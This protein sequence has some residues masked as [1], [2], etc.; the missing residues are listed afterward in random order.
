MVSPAAGRCRSFLHLGCSYICTVFL[1]CLPPCK[2]LM[3]LPACKASR[4]SSSCLAA[5]DSGMRVMHS[6]ALHFDLGCSLRAC[7]WP[8]GFRCSRGKSPI[9]PSLGHES[10]TRMWPTSFN[11]MH[12]H[13]APECLSWIASQHFKWATQCAATKQQYLVH[14]TSK[15][16][17]L[18]AA[19]WPQPVQSS[20]D[21]LHN[22]DCQDTAGPTP[23]FVLQCTVRPNYSITASVHPLL[24]PC[25]PTRGVAAPS[26]QQSWMLSQGCYQNLHAHACGFMHTCCMLVTSCTH[27]STTRCCDRPTPA[28]ELCGSTWNFCN[29]QETTSSRVVTV[30]AVTAAASNSA[31]GVV[32]RSIQ[33]LVRQWKVVPSARARGS[34]EGQTW[35]IA[36]RPEQ[37]GS[38]RQ[39][40]PTFI[41]I[42][43]HPRVHMCTEPPKRHGSKGTANRGFANNGA[44]FRTPLQRIVA[45]FTTFNWLVECQGD[46]AAS[47]GA[48]LFFGP[49]LGPHSQTLPPL[50]VAAT[51][52]P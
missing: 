31:V 43:S 28:A 50:L 17:Q 1:D 29:G 23:R 16:K 38:L 10:F 44:T 27:S 6:H 9:I 46:A 26:P 14:C 11:N 36:S 45:I 3:V 48:R 24:C 7:D 2:I 49:A 12:R 21:S 15:R 22:S 41:N 19:A 20:Q 30:I 47:S 40:L 52:H 18:Q 5:L 4:A 39:G 8:T 35:Y 42:T 51:A 33:G 25:S 13:W 37:E 32:Q 34:A